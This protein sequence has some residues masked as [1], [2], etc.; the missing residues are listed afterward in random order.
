MTCHTPA[1]EA[2]E[3]LSLMCASPTCLQTLLC[4]GICIMWSVSSSVVFCTSLKHWLFP[5]T[6]EGFHA[7]TALSDDAPG[8]V[9]ADSTFW[10]LLI[11]TGWQFHWWCMCLTYPRFSLEGP[12][13]FLW[14]HSPK[15]SL[16]FCIPRLHYCSA[17]SLHLSGVRDNRMWHG[18]VILTDATVPKTLC[19]RDDQNFLVQ[20]R[21]FSSWTYTSKY[22]SYFKQEHWVLFS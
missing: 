17:L 4:Q 16:S 7:L 20:E 21:S 2:A 3:H 10:S 8:N 1:V 18:P 12:H 6:V 11:S 9:K 13:I 14:I 15:R 19:F 22:V 5:K